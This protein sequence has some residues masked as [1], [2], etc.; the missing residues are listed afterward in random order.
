[1][2]PFIE[3]IQSINTIDG[4]IEELKKHTIITPKLKNIIDFSIKAHDNQF[5]KSGEPYAVHPLLVASITAYFSPDE[6]V[7]AT[8]LLHDVVE[9]TE[10]DLTFVKENWGEDIA[11][12]VDGLTKIVEIRESEFSSSLSTHEAKTISSAMTFRKMLIASIDDVRVLLVKLCDRFHNML[13]LDALPENKQKR[14]AEETLVVYVPIAHRLGISTLKNHLEDLAFYYIYPKE[15]NK[16]DKFI[17][18]HQHAIQ[19]TFNNFISNTKNILE[20]NGYDASKVK[21]LSRIKHHYSIYLKMQRK[22]VSIDEVLDLLAIRVLVPE[23]IDCYKVLG[24]LH[25]AYKPLISR[26]KDYVSTPKENGYRTIHTTVFYNSKIYEIQIRSFEMHKIAEYGIAA[27]WKYKSGAKNGPN[28]NWLKSLEFSNENVEEFYADTKDDLYSEE[29]V[30]Y[31][32]HGDTFNLPRGSTAY[33][34]AYAVHTDVGKNAFECFI[35]KIKKPLL[36]EL[37]SSDIV[38]IKTTDYPILRCSWVDMVK[39]NRAKKQIKMLCSHRQKELNELTGKNILDTIFVRYTQ[40]ITNTHNFDSLHK[41][42]N[43]LDFLRHIKK[44]IETRMIKEHGLVTRF[45]IL[46]SKLKKYKF[47]NILIYSNFSI[48]SVSF[49]HCCH[50]KF[51]DDIVAFKDGNKAIIHHKMCDKAYK[52]IKSKQNMLFCKWTKDTLYPYKMVV[53]LA[54]TKG[55]LAKLLMYMS[56]YEGY[57]LSVDYG[58]EKHSY[59]QYCDIDFEI[60]NSNVEEVR[61]IVEQKAKV[62]EF[63]SKKDAY[64]K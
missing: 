10:Y 19:L 52:K 4:A 46:A 13:T 43:N 34:F 39:T 1:M 41:I 12:M 18:D 20:K 50:P 47:D 6:A 28:L 32:P 36:T 29:I 55:E 11:H 63:F 64:N 62:I 58:R 44:Q 51:G 27:H 3:T 8:S 37:K 16:I 15:Y 23:E 35:N 31:S 7:V 42:A 61:K 56:K 53:S 30:V 5:R 33:D 22:G 14:I 59:R 9:D 21:I 24:H 40:E 45:K 25:L 26:F 2:D 49:D 17:K 60:N 48:N 38:A 57:I 54:N